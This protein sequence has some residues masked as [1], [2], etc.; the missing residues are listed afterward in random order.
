MENIDKKINLYKL[1][2]KAIIKK[3]NN[4]EKKFTLEEHIQDIINKLEQVYL[5]ETRAYIE[6]LRYDQETLPPFLWQDKACLQ[7]KFHAIFLGYIDKII[8]S[9]KKRLIYGD[10]NENNRYLSLRKQILSNLVYN[11]EFDD[12]EI[13]IKILENIPSYNLFPKL[14]EDSIIYKLQVPLHQELINA[15]NIGFT[16]SK[17]YTFEEIYMLYID[18]RSE[19]DILRK[20]SISIVNKEVKSKKL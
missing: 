19:F 4:S 7:I 6:A 12:L 5:I 17:T 16:C 20:S 3:Y 11:F 10:S 1:V 9:N 2:S 8:E 18:F 13:F 14:Y 15:Y